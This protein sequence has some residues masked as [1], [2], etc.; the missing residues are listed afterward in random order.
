MTVQNPAVFIQSESHPA[1]DVRRML[2]A[3]AGGDGLG[4]VVRDTHLAVT[5]KSGTPDMSVDVAG[6]MIWIPGDEGSYQGLYFAENRGTTNL[7]ISAADPTNARKDLVVAKVQDSAYS[8]ATDA[9][10]LAVVTGTP[11][12]SPSEPSA[13][14]NSVVL[15]MVDVAAAAT[16]I[17]DANITDRRTTSTKGL[18]PKGIRVGLSTDKPTSYWVGTALYATDNDHFLLYDGSGW[19][20]PQNVAWGVNNWDATGVGEYSLT[21][22]NTATWTES[23]T[24]RSDRQ[25]MITGYASGIM[26]DTTG[27][28]TST[29][30]QLTLTYNSSTVA[31]SRFWADDTTDSNVAEAI[32]FTALVTGTGSAANVSIA[33]A[34]SLGRG[35]DMDCYDTYCQYVITD[36]GPA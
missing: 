11:A 4:G 29:R 25:Y 35:F 5:E 19:N 26:S 31:Q 10:S 36:V 32:P 16:S 30:M 9:W 7:S 24:L 1:E 28:G 15:A 21:S 3:L 23:V 22:G 18:I 6:G 34:D 20:P 14:S 13:P 27:T 8:G 33:F 12:G 17:V 2:Y